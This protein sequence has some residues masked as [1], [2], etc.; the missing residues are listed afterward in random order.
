[1]ERYVIPCIEN[2]VE[3][4]ERAFRFI[5]EICNKKKEAKRIA[6]YLPAKKQLEHSN[7]E[8]FLGSD[9]VKSLLKGNKISF[10]SGTSLGLEF[11]SSASNIRNYDGVIAFYTDDDVL[12]KLHDFSELEYVVA[13]PW[14]A[15]DIHRWV[16]VYNPNIVGCT[17]AQSDT[18]EKPSPSLLTALQALTKSVNLRDGGVHPSDQKTAIDIFWRLRKLGILLD[19]DKIH[20]EALKLGWTPNGAKHLVDIVV[21]LNGRK[22]DPPEYKNI[23]I[24]SFCLS[25]N[26]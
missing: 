19:P 13:I 21:K 18:S 22:S 9:N 11:V 15:D 24:R 17:S 7:I 1:M 16:S 20:V 25:L 3:Q 6:L 10:L 26:R 23:G 14:C 4:T 12:E 5:N 8:P 2:P